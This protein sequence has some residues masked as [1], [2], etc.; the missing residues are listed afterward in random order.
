MEGTFK[1]GT[2]SESQISLNVSSHLKGTPTEKAFLGIQPDN[3][4]I[5]DGSTSSATPSFEAMLEATA[6]LG[7]EQLLYWNTG[8]NP[9]ICKADSHINVQYGKEY[10][11]G[12]SFEKVHISSEQEENLS[13]S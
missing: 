1:N 4:T 3:G 6:R 13:L 12:S 7:D 9:F 10:N 2:F 8:K 11:F 5:I